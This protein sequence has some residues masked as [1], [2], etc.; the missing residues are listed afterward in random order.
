MHDRQD[1]NPRSMQAALT[2]MADMAPA[3]AQVLILGEMAHLAEEAVVHHQRLGAMVAA[4]EPAFVAFIGEGLAR[5]MA[6][7]ASRAGLANDRMLVSSPDRLEAV[8][9]VLTRHL[10]DP[11]VALLKGGH[12]LH[13]EAL[14]PHLGAQPA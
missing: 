10:R 13:L 9:R 6:R 8:G 5:E 2:L 7:G 4:L 12:H 1:A 11:R 3:S 14:L